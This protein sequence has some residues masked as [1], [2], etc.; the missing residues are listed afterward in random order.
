M[1]ILL[2][3]ALN[4]IVT[5]YI[6]T[7]ALRRLLH[8]MFNYIINLSMEFYARKLSREVIAAV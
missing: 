2:V 6:S 8:K 1:Q 5:T 4:C 3:N 7:L